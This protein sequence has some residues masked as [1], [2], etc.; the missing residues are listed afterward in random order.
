MNEARSELCALYLILK[1]DV[2]QCKE[3]LSD[4]Y[5]GVWDR[6]YTKAVFSMIEGI[7]FRIRQYVVSAVD[8]G[9]YSLD[10]PSI[11]FLSETTYKIDLSGKIKEK[12]EYLVFLPGF[13]FTFKSFGRC[14]GMEEFVEKAFGDNGFNNFKKSVDIRNRLTH[15]KR[16]Q[17]MRVGG[18]ELELIESSEEWF[19]ALVLPLIE[20]AFEIEN[21]SNAKFGESASA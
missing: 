3:L 1:S 17:E 18:S 16:T 15:P 5:T 14:L 20:R 21:Q 7:S 2:D 13:K 12:G 10:I 8:A 6:V 11:N 4:K 9:L 19:H